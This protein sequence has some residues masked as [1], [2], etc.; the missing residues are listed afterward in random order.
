MKLYSSLHD[1][2]LYNWEQF[3]RTNDAFFLIDPSS[4][5][6]SDRMIKIFNQ[7]HGSKLFTDEQVAE[8]YF[9]LLDQ[10]FEMTDSKL[11]LEER[12]ELIR[13]LMQARVLY[14]E[15]DES[16]INIINYY[17]F[18]LKD[19]E[20]DVKID[21]IKNRMIIQKFYGISINP[22]ETTVAEFIK[23]SEIVRESHTKKPSNS[24]EYAAD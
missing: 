5:K 10:F 19:E 16:Q 14:V 6:F 20:Q 21:P 15:G 1:L 11:D 12:A 8:C 13:E 17:E 18:L 3:A 22:K 9:S 23:I 7:K 24:E 2:P 4:D